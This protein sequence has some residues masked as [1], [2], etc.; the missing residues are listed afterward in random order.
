MASSSVAVGFVRLTWLK[1]APQVLPCEDYFQPENPE[2]IFIAP[3]YC[4]EA[5]NHLFQIPK[6]PGF[7]P[8]GLALLPNP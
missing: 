1:V 4:L 3:A 2:R 8:A 7:R 6:K 5:I